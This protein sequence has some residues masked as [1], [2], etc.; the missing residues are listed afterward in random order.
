MRV[1]IFFYFCVGVAL[2]VFGCSLLNPPSAFAP[3]AFVALGAL[4]LFAS[5]AGF[6]WAAS[7]RCCSITT[8]NKSSS[9][10]ITC[11]TPA[12]TLP[13]SLLGLCCADSLTPPRSGATDV[14]MPHLAVG[15][16]VH[17]VLLRN[18]PSSLATLTET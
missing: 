9:A 14:G 3:A 8:I 7:A 6:W 5:M 10:S 15:V 16:V 13:A 17:S 1:A 11:H 2:I 4:N 18:Q 12:D